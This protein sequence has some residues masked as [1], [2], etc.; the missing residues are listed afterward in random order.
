MIEQENERLKK[1]ITKNGASVDSRHSNPPLPSNFNRRQ[2]ERQQTEHEMTLQRLKKLLSQSRSSYS[3]RDFD[4]DY[5]KK[6]D[7]QRRMSRF[8]DPKK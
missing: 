4:E 8:S 3:K 2:R 7:I 6:Q 1:R 5:A